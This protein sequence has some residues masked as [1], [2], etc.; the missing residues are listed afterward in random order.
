MA[1]RAYKEAI[2]KPTTQNKREKEMQ[3]I[4]TNQET[5]EKVKDSAN[6]EFDPEKLL[7][8]FTDATKE[9]DNLVASSTSQEELNKILNSKLSHAEEA[10]RMIE[11]K[12]KDL[13]SNLTDSQ[14]TAINNLKN[15]T[16]KYWNGVTCGWFNR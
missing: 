11:E 10:E 13:E 1:K 14:K 4:T 15:N 9:L 16:T 7:N 8:E 6:E 5:N 2:K 12:I 3:N